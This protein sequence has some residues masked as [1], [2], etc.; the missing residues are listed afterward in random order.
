MNSLL[1]SGQSVLTAGQLDWRIFGADRWTLSAD[2]WTG[3]QSAESAE[4]AVGGPRTTDTIE[5]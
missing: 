4:I 2:R 3:E 5:E 1:T